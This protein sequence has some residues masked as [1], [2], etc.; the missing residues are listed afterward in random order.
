MVQHIMCGESTPILSGAIPAFELFMSRWE[1]CLETQPCL[2]TYIEPG[3]KCAYE[4][5]RRMDRT[6]AYILAMGKP[7]SCPRSY[8]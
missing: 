6:N 1:T 3:L 2:K 5:Y 4:Y 8:S 7:A